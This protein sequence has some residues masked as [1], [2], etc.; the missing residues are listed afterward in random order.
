M[1]KLILSLVIITSLVSICHGGGRRLS[2]TQII[3]KGTP[4]PTQTPTP[5]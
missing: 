4:V 2:D 5:K 1:N 3:R